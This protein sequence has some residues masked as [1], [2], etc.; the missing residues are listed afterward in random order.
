MA[1][2]EMNLRDYWLIVRR[3][4]M[5]IIVCT[6]L[7]ALFSFWFAKQKVPIYQATAAVKFEQS[8]SLSGLL[9]EVL[10]YS[11]ADNIETQVTLIKSYPV[12]EE[13][14]R[15][16]GKLPPATSGQ[17]VRES[18]SYQATLDGLG[19]KLRATRV[20]STSI[21]EIQA[22]SPNAREAREL[23]NTV[24][25]VYREYNRANR[26]ARVIEAR[27]FIEAQL[28]EVEGRVKRAEEEVWAFRD[29]N[30]IIAPGAE[31]S[32]LLSLFTQVRGDIERAR[33][34]RTEMEAM[35][36]RLARNGG[37]ERI[38]VDNSNPNLARLATLQSELT[39]E[40]TNLA[41]EVTDKH[42][43][44]QA[45]DDRL[46]EVRAE[47]RREVATQIAALRNREDILGRQM[48]DLLAKNREVPATELS[49][50]R[51]QR[52][53]KVN[54]D[55]LTL[56]KTRHQEALIK[57][58][59]GVEE[60][61]IVRP[62]TDPVAPSGSE[63][64]NTVLVGA[65]LGLMLGL[66][67][68][69]VQET[70][71]TSI[72]TIEDVESY[73][74]VRVL[75]IVPHIDPRETMQ[76]LIERRPSLAQM[77]PDALQ[78][79]A[80]LITHFDPKSP[81]AE[82]YRTLRTN[83]QFERMERGGKVLVVTSPTLQ[84][85][86]TTTI[87]N[88]ALTM[89]QNGQKTLLVGGNMRRPSIYRFFGIEREPGLSDILVGN[90]NW[91]DCVRGVADILMG[92]F[93]MEDVMAAPGLDNLHIIEA[94]PIPAN[95]SELLST[96][97]MTEFLRAVAA[98]YDIV[99]IDTPPILPVTDSAIVAG[100]ADGVLLVYQAGK[101][102]RLVLKRAKSH[103]EAARAQVWGVVLND[104]QTEVSGYTYTHYY[105]HYYGEEQ[106]GEANGAS[107]GGRIQRAMERARGWFGRSRSAAAE[108]SD[109][110]T[111]L[112]VATL[113]SPRER[114]SRGKTLLL[115]LA[116]VLGVA[117]AAGLVAAWRLGLDPT[118]P[119]ELLRQRLNPP[120]TSTPPRP[121]PPPAAK[122]AP[123]PPPAGAV[124]TPAPASTT[125][126][127]PASKAPAPAAPT[128][129]PVTPPPAPPAAA[130]PA[131][132]APLTTTPAPTPASPPTAPA[133]T[134]AAAPMPAD[135]TPPPKPRATSPAPTAPPP[136]TA[137]A[138]ARVTTPP[139]AST[140]PAPKPAPAAAATPA[141]AASKP[142]APASKPA[143][144]ASKPTSSAAARPAPPTPMVASVVPPP[145][146]PRAATSA[147]ARFAIEFGPFVTAAEAERVERRLTEAG[148]ATVRFR[149]PSGA[150]V[151][152]VLIERV[153]SAHEGRAVAAAVR[154]QGLGEA[155]MI[156]TDP[157][158][159]RVGAALPLRGAV[160]LAERVRA[161]GHQVRVAAQP[162]EASAFIVR[163]G[164]FA[165]R[166]EAEARNQELAPLELPAHQV[167]QVR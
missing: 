152:A 113:R 151:Y 40:R 51:L 36:A 146:Q 133:P 21:I 72:G 91:R 140:P 129:A 6:V 17:A 148:H 64:I 154:E 167:V 131:T 39:L 60:V 153:P 126:G 41:L 108:E 84:E 120:A 28:R 20:P 24:A 107:T 75:G 137:P 2:Y 9:V 117:A 33:Q 102:G 112:T 136:V 76:R 8:T 141:P 7:V 70:L 53:A 61:S 18:R 93:E 83:I 161:A 3:R 114:G 48:G 158:T 55:L 103:L 116:G 95:P 57:E 79:H 159:L 147:A 86:K 73:L 125:P 23:A 42:P 65:L 106:P 19:A 122:P 45:L 49:L 142:A 100:K 58:S 26:N 104:L 30:R 105:T 34:Q 46:R 37:D 27:K 67:L 111:G 59:E 77:E 143:A 69:F 162:G 124:T 1:Q 97:A 99:L 78:S 56:L 101:V 149:Q 160:E 32:V 63:W 68:A 54:D 31:S 156:S 144:P 115:A 62:A 123:V 38:F 44:L 80:L 22:S 29:A 52:D 150:T 119:R 92:R 14:A 82:A 166:D 163:H 88:L 157:V 138:P 109:S 47:M 155:V 85:G 134:S 12:L 128:P 139:T 35:Q 10:S 118:N 5:I 90:A 89:A 15:R 135:V 11:S 25:E 94:G 165:T 74:G 127:A 96:A 110:D 4:R 16:L 164:G 145:G 98:E 130:A 71:D 50:Q 132:T 43:R 66:V 13:V 87:V 121:T 81:V